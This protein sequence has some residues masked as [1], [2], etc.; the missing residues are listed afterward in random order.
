M[1]T[2]SFSVLSLLSFPWFIALRFWELYWLDRNGKEREGLLVPCLKVLPLSIASCVRLLSMASRAQKPV[3]LFTRYHEGLL[4]L[5]KDCIYWDS[6]ALLSLPPCMC[7]IKLVDYAC[8][9]IFVS[10]VTCIWLRYM[11]LTLSPTWFV[12]YWE[13]WLLWSSEAW[14]KSVWPVLLLSASLA[15]CQSSASTTEQACSA[16][17]CRLYQ[18]V[19][20]TPVL[21]L[22]LRFGRTWPGSCPVSGFPFPKLFI[23]TSV[24]F[25]E[26]TYVFYSLL[27]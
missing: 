16:P 27:N 7:S 20:G 24:I 2:S 19:W 11:F 14:D 8:G 1:L 10:L 12:F 5:V 17:L 25:Y 23:T 18:S 9:I 22:W 4:S 3:P 15:S 21:A 6:I 26:N 13:L